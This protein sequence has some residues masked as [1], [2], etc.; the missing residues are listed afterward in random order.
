VLGARNDPRFGHRAALYQL[1]A[2]AT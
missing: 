1:V 2:Y